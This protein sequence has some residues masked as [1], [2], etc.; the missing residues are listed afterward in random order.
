M[1]LKIFILSF[2]MLI[3]EFIILDLL[4]YLFLYKLQ[5]PVITLGS[6]FITLKNIITNNYVQK[7]NYSSDSKSDLDTESASTEL[8][9]V[10]PVIVYL[11]TDLDKVSILK[12]NKGKAGVYR[13]INNV[14]GKTYIGSSIDIQSR[15]YIYFSPRILLDEVKFPTPI[16]SA[17][18][19]YGYSSFTLEILEYCD[20]NDAV[21]REQYY[22]DLL[23]PEYNILK[24]AGSMLGYKHTEE[25][26]K[27]FNER[28][29]SEETR[30]NLSKAATGRI[31]TEAEREKLSNIRKG[32]ILSEEIKKK[33][34]ETSTKLR[35]V[36]VKITDLETN[37]EL[38]FDNITKLATNLNVSRT[39]VRKCINKGSL[40][41]NRYKIEEQNK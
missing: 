5:S 16:Y 41:K 7:R 40:L 21:K 33:I 31:L 1:I 14:N 8:P 2:I 10:K 26:L 9:E 37:E 13:W 29:V 38:L 34:S 11:N 18:R 15:M 17:L 24:V 20:R 32:L 25:T 30:K 28:V 36:T 19:K 22:M 35:G 39:V 4:C 6:R 12:D 23:Q 27:K 3:I